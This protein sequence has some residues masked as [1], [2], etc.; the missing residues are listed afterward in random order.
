MITTNKRKRTVVALEAYATPQSL[1]LNATHIRTHPNSYRTSSSLSREGILFEVNTAMKYLLVYSAVVILALRETLA[2]SPSP[3]KLELRNRTHLL[4]NPAFINSNL[5]AHAQDYHAHD[6]ESVGEH[7]AEN[8]KALSVIAAFVVF[9]SM[10]LPAHAVDIT[11]GNQLF[12]GNCAGCHAG[13]MNFVKEQ[14]T[15]KSEAL[16]K[17]VGSR[18]GDDLKNWVMGS[19]QH[20]RNVYFK[21]PSGNGK[22]TESEFADV[23][24]FISDQAI[25]E[26]W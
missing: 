15:L 14:K 6:H 5:H 25:K 16:M 26:A 9:S 21:A 8:T 3:T 7:A 17:Y 1:L 20:Q 10:T 22:L 11:K 12:S 4:D 13:G 24:A 23:T 19:G 2:F 18:E